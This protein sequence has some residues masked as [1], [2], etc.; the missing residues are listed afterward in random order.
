M[1]QVLL[2]IIKDPAEGDFLY[3]FLRDLISWKRKKV[4]NC[5]PCL[6]KNELLVICEPQGEPQET[7]KWYPYDWLVLPAI[8]NLM[9]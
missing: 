7:I 6:L 4:A 2:W 5:L 3:R 8:Q 9:V 1:G